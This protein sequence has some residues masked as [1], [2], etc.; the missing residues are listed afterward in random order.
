MALV[1]ELGEILQS[2]YLLILMFLAFTQHATD[3]I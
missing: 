2:S 3:E 1:S